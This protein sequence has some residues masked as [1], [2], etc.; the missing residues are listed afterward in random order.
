MHLSFVL[1]LY[2]GIERELISITFTKIEDCNYYANELIKRFSTH[3]ISVKDRAVAYCI[4]K[5][6]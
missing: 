6:E 3:G 2:L 5:T 4:L 1:L